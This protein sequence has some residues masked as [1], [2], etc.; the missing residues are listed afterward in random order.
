KGGLILTMKRCLR[1]RGE[2]GGTTAIVID[3]AQNLSDRAF[4]ELRLLSNFETYTQ[5][6]IQ[7]VL[8]GQPELEDRL[9]QPHLRQLRER[10]SVRTVV[11]PLPKKE[12]RR[13]IEH[14]LQRSGGS[15]RQ[16]FT[17]PALHVIIRRAAGRS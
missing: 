5:K 6:L 7:I 4:E 2:E 17:G 15:A 9:R 8:V 1:R 13:Y 11:N 12:M 10:V 16:L 3:E 14:R